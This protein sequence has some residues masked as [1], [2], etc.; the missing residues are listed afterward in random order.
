MVG[1]V[2]PT[3][4]TRAGRRARSRRAAANDGLILDAALAIVRESGWDAVTASGVADRAGLTPTPIISRFSDLS[5]LGAA[6]WNERLGSP[7]RS[8]M[9]AAIEATH[10]T[11]RRAKLPRA[12]AAF[13]SP[14]IDLIAAAD[15]CLAAQFEPYLARTIHQDIAHVL[16]AAC[17]PSRRVTRTQAAQSAYVMALAFGLLMM[18]QRMAWS[19]VD[20]DPQII[21]LARA[22]DH[23]TRPVRLP[24]VTTDD[25]APLVVPS[26]DPVLDD[27]LA[28]TL[29]EVGLHGYRR[30]TM[31]RIAAAARVSQGFIFGRYSSKR[32]LFIDATARRHKAALDSSA[33][34]LSGLQERRG[35]GVA[36]ATVMKFLM[37]PGID[38]NRALQLEQQRM[39]WYDVSLQAEIDK[40]MSQYLEQSWPS[41]SESTGESAPGQQHLDLAL[42]LGVTMLPPVLPEAWRLPFDVVT[43][44]LLG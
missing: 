30:A 21:E 4:A 10:A 13:A 2:N 36:E 17:T 7:L 31:Q 18:W 24:E 33:T 37:Q 5:A 19:P 40:A 3:G 22:L 28:A 16:K 6:L 26:G 27:L 43:V 14:S 42:G 1:S 12:M 23:P 32:E 15:L 8:A 29:V 34:H 35:M 39:S 41:I 9:E 20:I 44:P 38:L 25:L 11:N